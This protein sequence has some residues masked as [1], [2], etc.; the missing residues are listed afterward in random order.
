MF[1]SPNISCNLYLIMPIAAEFFRLEN[2]VIQLFAKQI[3]DQDLKIDNPSSTQCGWM[4]CT[5]N[6]FESNGKQRR[7]EMLFM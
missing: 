3:Q 4:F 7:L 2:Y 1:S 6:E 5:G